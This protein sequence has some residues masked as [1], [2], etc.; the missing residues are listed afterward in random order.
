V[1]NPEL[2]KVEPRKVR[3]QVSE[4]ADERRRARREVDEDEALP[5]LETD[6]DETEVLEPERFEV[7]GVLG[8][9]QLP[10]EVV[11]P[12]VV[13]ALEPDGTAA[14]LLDDGRAT[15][16]ETLKN[17]RSVPSRPRAMSSGSSSTVAR[18]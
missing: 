10:F 11:D 4:P 2:R 12:G 5:G 17:A 9:D 8:A 18:K 16:A 7:V 3:R 1:R 13:G 14:R 6:G 15:V